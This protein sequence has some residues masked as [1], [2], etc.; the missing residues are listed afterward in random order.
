[1]G[2]NSKR[3]PRERERERLLESE[4]ES[5]NHIKKAELQKRDSLF[6]RN[7]SVGKLF[8]VIN[9]SARNGQLSVFAKSFCLL[10]CDMRLIRADNRRKI[11]MSR[12]NKEKHLIKTLINCQIRH[13]GE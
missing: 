9:R 6:T 1:M 8:L 5:I 12:H 3:F 7:F 4:K 13:S 10:L 11:N 2:A